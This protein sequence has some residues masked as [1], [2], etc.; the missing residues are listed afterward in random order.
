V[1]V[2][3]RLRCMTVLVRD[4]FSSGSVVLLLD[5]GAGGPEGACWDS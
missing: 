4:L 1:A 3:S 2:C 5:P